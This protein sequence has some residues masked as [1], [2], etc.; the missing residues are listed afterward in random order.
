MNHADRARRSLASL[1]RRAGTLLA[2]RAS[3]P[4]A[5]ATPRPGPPRRKER[6][7][8]SAP[9]RTTVISE[10]LG[11]ARPQAPRERLRTRILPARLPHAIQLCIHCQ[12][13]PAGFW[14]SRTGA[15][16]VR[17]PWCL[18]CC[19]ELDRDHCDVIRFAP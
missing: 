12:D 16:T 10:P 2:H 11:V 6:S 15:K 3:G 18:S 9:V 8:L 13:R 5:A 19:E 17:R 1:T 7:P 4:V 14:V